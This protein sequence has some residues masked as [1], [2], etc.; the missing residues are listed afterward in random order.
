MTTKLSAPELVEYLRAG[1]AEELPHLSCT[2]ELRDET[3]Y[4]KAVEA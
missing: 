3:I 1:L 4:V 2:V